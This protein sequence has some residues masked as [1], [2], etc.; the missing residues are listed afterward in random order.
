VTQYI[1]NTD[2]DKLIVFN[3]IFVVNIYFKNNIQKQT[4]IFNLGLL[5]NY[6]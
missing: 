5:T 3:L 4:I 2:K 1:P 6:E